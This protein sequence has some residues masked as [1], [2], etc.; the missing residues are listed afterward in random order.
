LTSRK[1]LFAF[2]CLERPDWYIYIEGGLG[3]P[4]EMWHGKPGAMFC[5]K[6]TSTTRIGALYMFESDRKNTVFCQEVTNTVLDT[7]TARWNDR[8]ELIIEEPTPAFLAL[9][10]IPDPRLSLANLPPQVDNA[11]Y[12]LASPYSHPDKEIVLQRYKE[13][14]A[15]GAV[16]LKMGYALIQPIA[17]AHVQAV[18]HQLPTNWEF[19][20]SID[21]RL[22]SVCR[23]VIVLMLPGVEDSKG[24]NAEI[25]YAKKIG[26]PV[27]KV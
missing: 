6:I 16:L 19:W 15:F 23:G 9:L 22:I 3:R 1:C 17:M 13:V 25:E 12:Y 18:E 11:V 5:E 10:N 27:Y 20:K 8:T 21:E 26:L 14:V 7:N 4:S 24:V 2:S